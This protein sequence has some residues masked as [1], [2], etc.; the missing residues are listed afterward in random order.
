MEVGKTQASV[1][2]VVEP[3]EVGARAVGTQ[4]G[5]LLIVIRHITAPPFPQRRSQINR[6]RQR[7]CL[8]DPAPFDHFYQSLARRLNRDIQNRQ[9]SEPGTLELTQI[10]MM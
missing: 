6:Q 9:G 7:E 2:N 4:E 8:A 5:R 1:I 10:G 3:L